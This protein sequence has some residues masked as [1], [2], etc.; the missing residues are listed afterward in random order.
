MYNTFG[1][2]S[3]STYPGWVEVD[4][5]N[6]TV[7]FDNTVYGGLFQNFSSYSMIESN[8]ITSPLD[9]TN[10]FIACNCGEGY[11]A[12]LIFTE[13]GSNNT[14]SFN[15]VN[16]QTA[17]PDFGAAGN[18]DQG[19]D[20]DIFILDESYDTIESN[21]LQNTFDCGVETWGNITHTSVW[22]NVITNVWNGICSYYYASW[23]NDTISYNT[24]ST[25]HTLWYFIR[26]DGGL[27]AANSQWSGFP[28]DTGVYFQNNTFQGNRYSS[29]LSA[30]ATEGSASVNLVLDTNYTTINTCF[31][32]G[33]LDNTEYPLDYDMQPN[34]PGGSD[35]YGGTNPTAGQFYIGSNTFSDNNFGTS[36]LAPLFGVYRNSGGTPQTYPSGLVTDGGGNICNTSA[37]GASYPITCQ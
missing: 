13:G 20:D 19:T 5:S 8:T 12:E 9:S 2:S 36:N 28:A 34:G 27:R 4:N 35:G 23:A 1:V 25:A 16:G 6:Y 33:T 21:V 30:N 7:F 26:E 37:N 14:I 29:P 18:A 32:C 3:H 15:T 22:G 10:P 11:Y 31:S 24:V 17:T